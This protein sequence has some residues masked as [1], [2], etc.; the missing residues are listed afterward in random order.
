M[1]VIKQAIIMAAGLGSR[2]KPLTLTTPKPLLKVNDKILIEALIENLS[3]KNIEKIFIVVGYQYEKFTYLTIKYP[4]VKLL[5]NENYAKHNNISSLYVA[6]EYLENTIILDG[7]QIINNKAVLNFDTENSGYCATYINKFSKEWI[8]ETDNNRMIK[9]C[10][11][12]GYN[13]GYQLF[14]LSFWE[15]SQAALLKKYLEY[16]YIQQQNTNI[17][18]DDVWRLH[19][20]NFRLKVFP[21][22]SKDIIEI[23]TLDELISIDKKYLHYADL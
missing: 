12:H 19:L 23:D 11:P 14:S 20:E 17:Y 3:A 1:S 9:T 16:E 4:S 10:H 5:F 18:W 22:A 13:Q 8:L 15:K 6:R 21:I 2:L 7:D